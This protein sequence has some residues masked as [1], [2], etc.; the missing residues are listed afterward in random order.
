L[1]SLITNVQ[2]LTVMALAVMLMVVMLLSTIHLGVLIW[3][4]ILK[5][6]RWLIAV[7][8]LLEIFG[9][10]LLVLIGVELLETLKAYVRKDVIHVRVVLEVALIAMARKVIIEEPNTVPGVTLFGIAALILALGIAF[11][12]ERQAKRETGHGIL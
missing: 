11:F 5:P 1:E 2:K 8:G 3:E 10:F 6:P 7:Q 9:Y 12:F 4:E